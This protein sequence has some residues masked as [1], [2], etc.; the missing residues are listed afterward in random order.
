MLLQY[1]TPRLILKILKPDCA[2]MV[3]DFYNR[4]RELFEKYEIDR[5]PD[6]YTVRY[7][8]K[9]LKFEYSAAMKLNTIR[10]YVFSKSEPDK[11]IGTVCLHNIVNFFYRSCEIGY[12]FSSEYHH[13]GMAQE[14]IRLVLR[15]AFDELNLHRVT[16][17]VCLGNQPSATLLER[18]GFHQEGVLRDYLM[19]HGRWQSHM[20][21]SLLINDFYN[22][23]EQNQ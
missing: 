14:A 12:K 8:H 16:A 20:L 10:F 17:V 15:L 13:Q 7:Q 18:L 2:P 1:E 22:S 5:V 23:S 21:F 6:F 9:I 4:D 19:L 3:L 11:I